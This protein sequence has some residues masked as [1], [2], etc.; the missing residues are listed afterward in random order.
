MAVYGLTLDGAGAG[1]A[2]LFA[3][4]WS[5]LLRPQ[6]Y[7][8]ALGQAFFSLGLG[9]A[10]FYTCG[11]YL[12]VEH[13]L[14]GLAGAIVVGDTLVAL[15]AGV[16]IFAAVFAFGLSPAAG[17]ELAFITLPRIFSSMYAG[18][19]VALAFFALLVIGAL[20][21]MASMLELLVAMGLRR[22]PM[23]RRVLSILCG[24]AVFATGIPSALSFG[25][26]EDWTR[27]DKNI[28]DTVDYLAS[29]VLLPTG[30]LLIAVLVA[31][32]WRADDAMAM[33]GLTRPSGPAW[34]WLAE[35][36]API[37]TALIMLQGL[38]VT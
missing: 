26:L 13:R 32:G 24:V 3:P 38:L 18:Q 29:N 6:V 15:L 27:Q 23:L 35:W 10:I 33:G 5:A 14:P 22:T 11:S 28:L 16:A 19:W 36:L 12:P 8:A 31:W 9:G 30:G 2:F 4:D 17:P 7:L 20:T 25:L 1:L 21:S 37:L 34:L